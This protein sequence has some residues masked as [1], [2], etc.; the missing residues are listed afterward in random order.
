MKPALS[1]EAP[2]VSKHA[3]RNE[4]AISLVLESVRCKLLSAVETEGYHG[5]IPFA[6]DIV[7]QDLTMAVVNG[8]RIKLK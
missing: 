4:G 6:V 2:H 7:D 1:R 8:Q 3:R 5:T